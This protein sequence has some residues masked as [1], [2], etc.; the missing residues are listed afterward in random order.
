MIYSNEEK[1]KK[2]QRKIQKFKNYSVDL[3]GFH[4]KA[5]YVHY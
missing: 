3:V 5:I 4:G 2:I 1:F